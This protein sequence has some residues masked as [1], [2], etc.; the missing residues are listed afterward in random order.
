MMDVVSYYQGGKLVRREVLDA[1]VLGQGPTQ[2]T[3][4]R[5]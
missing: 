5:E 1:S 2:K 3:T 4:E